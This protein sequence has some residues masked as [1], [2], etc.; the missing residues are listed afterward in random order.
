VVALDIDGTLGDYHAHFLRFAEAYLGVQREWD[1]NGEARFKNWFCQRYDVSMGVWNDIKLA[2][3]QGAMKRSMPLFHEADLLVKM[4]RE[5]G[6]ELWMT[7]TR[8]H[9]RLDNIDPDTRAWLGRHGIE[10]EYMLFDEGKYPRLAEL[11]EPER[12][13]A[14]LDDLPEQYAEAAAVFGAEVPILRGTKWNSS[15]ALKHLRRADSLYQAAI[16][17]TS[18]VEEWQ[19]E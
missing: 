2:Y 10:Y 12:V 4:V 11:V 9:L 19:S 5:A 1:Y 15:P 3:R 7:T 16:T 17:I 18:R 13:V 8:P 6:A 14:V